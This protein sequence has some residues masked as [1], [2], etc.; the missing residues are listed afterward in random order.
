MGMPH[1]RAVLTSLSALAVAGAAAAAAAVPAGADV[2]GRTSSGSASVQL[3][4]NYLT[5]QIH[6]RSLARAI[7]GR[8]V[9][10]VCGRNLGPRAA[11]HERAT[12]TPAAVGPER[13]SFTFGASV[14]SK[15]DRCGVRKPGGGWYLKARLK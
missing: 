12:W 3:S 1:R 10:I 2:S 6:R 15:A 4:Q 5:V 9:V 14:E 11:A 8:Q 7:A 13:F